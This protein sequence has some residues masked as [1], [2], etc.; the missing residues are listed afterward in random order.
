MAEKDKKCKTWQKLLK[1]TCGMPG[2][3]KI[4]LFTKSVIFGAI[5]GREN[6]FKIISLFIIFVCEDSKQLLYRLYGAILQ[7]YAEKCPEDADDA[8]V[9]KLCGSAPPHPVR[10]P[11]NSNALGEMKNASNYN[12]CSWRFE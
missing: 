4:N 10:C 8:D 1:K 3:Q 9:S 11:V 7:F 6:F 12:Y 2:G 5:F